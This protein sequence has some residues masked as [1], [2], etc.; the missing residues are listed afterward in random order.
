MYW[1][2]LGLG[3]IG[4]RVVRLRFVVRRVL[5]VCYLASKVCPDVR[6]CLGWWILWI[7]GVLVIYLAFGF[8]VGLCNIDFVR[9]WYWSGFVAGLWFGYGLGCYLAGRV[10][11]RV[12]FGLV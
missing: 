4:G 8:S 12:G 6:V 7:F 9:L 10:C 3:G 1:W 2:V 11:G 5:L